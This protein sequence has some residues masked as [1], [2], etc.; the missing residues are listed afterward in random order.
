MKIKPHTWMII[1]PLVLGVVLLLL[2]TRN[3]E[4][5]PRLEEDE[6][7]VAVE[8]V[9][10]QEETLIPEA[11]GHGT[12]APS[13]I[14]AAVSQVQGS[15]TA[16]A[17]QLRPGAVVAEGSRLLQV[18]ESDYRLSLAEAEAALMATDASLQQLQVQNSN[19]TKSLKIEEELFESNEKEWR[20]LQQLAQQGTLSQSQ[21]DAQE[22]LYLTQK[23]QLQTTRNSLAL[24][25]GERHLLE[26]QQKQQ[27]VRLQQ[28][29]KMVAR[30]RFTAPFAARVAE[31]N[32]ELD[33]YVRSGERLLVL[34]DLSQAEV[35][36]QF[37]L[38]QFSA[39]LP[40]INLGEELKLKLDSAQAAALMQL[41]AKVELDLGGEVVAWDARF[42]R[43]LSTIDPKTRTVGVVVA[44]DEPYRRANPPFRPPLVKG[45]FVRVILTGP[46]RPQELMI[47]RS[48]LH[49]N[50]VYLLTPDQ[51]LEVRPV[52]VAAHYGERVAVRS[53][54]KVGEQLVVSR[55]TPAIS[56]MRLAP[57]Q[58]E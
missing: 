11:R 37:S 35:T 31:L 33:Q 38:A 3:R 42:L 18:D 23:R 24:L 26:A 43:T 9:T 22:R 17:D 4:E 19:L 55:L 30:T 45:M 53:G 2:M 57:L 48:A 27:Q 58:G 20:R 13:R 34:D 40:E 44:V 41:S 32:V 6:Q 28:A 49:D 50:R 5:V 12:V 25:P 14:W 7:P 10:L 51:R 47:P 16:L 52:T 46:P 54:V 1:P 39:L 36:A 21:L 56:G 29:E 15:V 8:V